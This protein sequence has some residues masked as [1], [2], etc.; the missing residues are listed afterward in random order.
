MRGYLLKTLALL[1]LGSNGL[2]AQNSPGE[3]EVF[4]WQF[5]FAAPDTGFTVL[6]G[7]SGWEEMSTETKVIAMAAP[8]PYE[9]MAADFQALQSEEGQRVIERKTTSIGGVSGLLLVLEFTPLKSDDPEPSYS[10]MFIRP[11]EQ[12]SLVL[13]AIYPKSQHE[14]LYPKMLAAFATVRK[15]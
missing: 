10:L 3:E 2:G 13:N 11:F 9:R 8:F 12:V 6:E 5:V 7:D 14:R 4:G 15:K 1:L